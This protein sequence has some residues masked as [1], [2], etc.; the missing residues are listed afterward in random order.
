[1]NSMGVGV[2][3]RADDFP[4]VL[5]HDTVLRPVDCG[6]PVVDL[7]GKV[8]GHQHRPCRPDRNLLPADRRVDRAD[9]RPDVRPAGAAGPH[10]T[11]LRPGRQAGAV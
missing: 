1:M 6:G 10:P 4:A 7:S 8:V 9:V 5:Q 3:S 2:S 11:A